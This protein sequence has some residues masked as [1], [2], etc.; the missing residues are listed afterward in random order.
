[1]TL[2]R[3]NNTSEMQVR[4]S[5]PIQIYLTVMNAKSF[6]PNTSTTEDLKLDTTQVVATSNHNWGYRSDSERTAL[7]C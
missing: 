7:N 2:L 6:L 3:I 1:M 5:Q 4:P